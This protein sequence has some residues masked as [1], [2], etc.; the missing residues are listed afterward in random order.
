MPLDTYTYAIIMALDT[1]ITAIAMALVN[2]A[3]IQHFPT[4]FDVT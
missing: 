1:Y 2:A 4:D 3:H